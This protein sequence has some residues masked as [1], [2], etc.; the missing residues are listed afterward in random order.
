MLRRTYVVELFFCSELREIGVGGWGKVGK[1]GN[2]VKIRKEKEEEET[3]DEGQRERVCG[4]ER[5]SAK[6]TN[7]RGER[8]RG[9]KTVV[10]SRHRP[11][12]VLP[13][14][15]T[16]P[17]EKLMSLSP[18]AAASFFFQEPGAFKNRFGG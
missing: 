14:K 1:V 7:L 3:K 5:P 10:G 15:Q 16:E 8:E 11:R 12:S 13:T 17:E 18:P 9:R 6:K 4:R 2:A